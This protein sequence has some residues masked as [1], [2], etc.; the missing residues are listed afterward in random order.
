VD[1]FKKE[2]SVIDSKQ[3]LSGKVIDKNIKD[4][5]EQSD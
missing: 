3:Q 4:A 2:Q 5:L 1:R